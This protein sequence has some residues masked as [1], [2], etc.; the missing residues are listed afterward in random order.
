MNEASLEVAAMSSVSRGTAVLRGH[1]NRLSI[2]E[3]DDGNI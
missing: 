1:R 3:V 2:L